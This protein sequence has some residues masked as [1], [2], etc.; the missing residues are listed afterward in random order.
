MKGEFEA[1]IVLRKLPLSRRS[2]NALQHLERYDAVLFTSKHAEEFFRKEIRRAAPLRIIRAGARNDLLKRD[3]KGKRALFPR[4]ALA[5][6]DIVRQLRAQ[7]AVVRVILLYTASGAV[8]LKREK[9][10]LLDGT[11][12]RLYFKS[13]SGIQ[14]FLRQFRGQQRRRV[15]SIPARCIGATTAAAARNAGFKK[16]FIR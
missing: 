5:P 15:L 14:G 11:V 3:L 6:A 1:R 9:K 7:G 16:V 4:S 12:K 8:L 2:K 13:P 10:M